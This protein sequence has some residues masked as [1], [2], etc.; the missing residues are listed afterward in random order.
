MLCFLVSFS[1]IEFSFAEGGLEEQL[2]D[3][4]VPENTA[5]PG[6]SRES[7]YSVQNRYSDLSKRF[8]FNLG[9]S[10]NMSSDSFL[11]M[12]ELDFTSRYHFTNRWNLAV[13]GSYGFNSFTDSANRLMAVDGIIPDVAIVKWRSDLLLGYN[14][15]YGKFRMSMDQVYYFDQYLAVGPGLVKTQFGTTPSAIADIGFALWFGKKWSARFGAKNEFFNEK[16]VSSSGT[17]YHLLGHLDIGYLIGEASAH[18]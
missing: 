1:S 11:N 8:E 13:S 5:P 17:A 4:R 10:K 2:T 15:F 14:L 16:R 12:T 18:E 7:L 3:L 9:G 6:I